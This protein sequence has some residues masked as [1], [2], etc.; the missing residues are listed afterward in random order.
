M[1]LYKVDAIVLRSVNM[2]EADQLLT[3]FSL[4]HGKIRVA[5]HGACKPTSKKR[6]AVQPFSYTRFLLRQGRELDSVSQC[7]SLELFWELRQQLKKLSYAIYLTEMV[8]AL[9]MPGETQK[10]IFW[11]LLNILRLLENND[12]DA[13]LLTRFFELKLVNYLGYQPSMDICAVCQ[14]PL[15]NGRLGFCPAA[16]GFL[17]SVCAHKEPHLFWCH[18]GTV[19]LLKLF[20]R[21][22]PAKLRKIKVNTESRK[23]MQLIMQKHLEYHLEH[24]AKSVRFLELMHK[25]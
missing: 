11:L 20:L 18:R 13:E 4:E 1:K 19:E 15:N 9:I 2:R 17:C 16:G 21:W 25:I 6:G 23:E 10:E 5:A 24:Q 7:E 12:N 14:G 8:D 22:P 3:L